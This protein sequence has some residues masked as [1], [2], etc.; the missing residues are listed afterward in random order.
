MKL[1]LPWK[2]A[3]L[4]ASKGKDAQE[5]VMYLEADHGQ[6]MGLMRE[7][8]QQERWRVPPH[9]MLRMGV[10]EGY[11]G[12]M[13]AAP[14]D[15]QASV[16]RS[17][18]ADMSKWDLTDSLVT[19]LVEQFPFTLAI[20]TCK[21][22]VLM[23]SRQDFPGAPLEQVMGSNVCDWLPPDAHDRVLRVY[24][25][26]AA[27][28]SWFESPDVIRT[29]CGLFL[30]RAWSGPSSSGHVVVINTPPVQIE[31]LEQAPPRDVIPL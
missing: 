10:V 6:R 29:E 18:L 30:T 31:S 1:V 7:D 16:F 11:Q 23:V 27:N 17:M 19:S 13:A 24:A 2:L 12:A 21:G 8:L 22:D 26:S 25:Q 20:V 9:V 4:V 3:A 15:V 28:G 5:P 14:A